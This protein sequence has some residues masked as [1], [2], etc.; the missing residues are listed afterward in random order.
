ML[1]ETCSCAFYIFQFIDPVISVFN[2]LFYCNVMMAASM[3]VCMALHVC[4]SMTF[5]RC[6]LAAAVWSPVIWLLRRL[7]VGRIVAASVRCTASCSSA[8]NYRISHS[9][10]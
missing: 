6:H 7:V 8:V 1:K 5:G 3:F 4:R 10:D 9:A 2:V